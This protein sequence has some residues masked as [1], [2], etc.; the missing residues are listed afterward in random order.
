MT[1]K[2]KVGD[3]MWWK[4]DGV[5]HEGIVKKCQDG[6]YA[7]KS[8]LIEAG[9]MVMCSVAEEGRLHHINDDLWEKGTVVNV[10]VVSVEE[11]TEGEQK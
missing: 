8:T 1:A 5:L 3:K 6:F 2:Y 4:V 10:E 9:T 11:I 7:I